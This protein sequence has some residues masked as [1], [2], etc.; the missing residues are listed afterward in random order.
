MPAR[1]PSSRS[2]A[3]REGVRKPV[4][5]CRHVTPFELAE[6]AARCCVEQHGGRAHGVTGGEQATEQHEASA[7]RSLARARTVRRRARATAA[8]RR[9]PGRCAAGPRRRGSVT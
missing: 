3:T 4:D 1:A 8:R 2:T 7:G 5:P 6:R 9:S